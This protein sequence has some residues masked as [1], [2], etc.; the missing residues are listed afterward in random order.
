MEPNQNRKPELSEPLSSEGQRAWL[1]DRERWCKE[2][3]SHT[4]DSGP[5]FF[6]TLFPMH[7]DVQKNTILENFCCILGAVGRQ[8]PAANPFS[9]PLILQEP[10]AERELPE[11]FFSASLSV[12]H[13]LQ[14]PVRKLFF[15][16]PKPEPEPSL[17]VTV[18]K[19][20][21]TPSTRKRA[22]YC[23]ESTVPEERTH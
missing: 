12:G 5:F 8:P 21:R 2:N 11:A 14:P 13:N 9:K 10:N 7:P 4:I 20:R 17:S 15:Q 22:E 16:E 1:A 3:P 6:C 23:F 18:L 19:H